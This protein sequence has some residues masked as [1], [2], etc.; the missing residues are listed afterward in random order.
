[1]FS[2]QHPSLHLHIY[3]TKALCPRWSHCHLP[4]HGERH[5]LAPR[6]PS[7]PLLLPPVVSLLPSSATHGAAPTP[8]PPHPL[9]RPT[10]SQICGRRR[11]I[12]LAC[13]VKEKDNADMWAHI[14]PHQ[15]KHEK[16]GPI[17]LRDIYI[18]IYV[19]FFARCVIVDG[20]DFRYCGLGTSNS[21]T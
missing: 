1:M 18:Y 13:M 12:D 20:R 7:P 14:M 17:L 16:I 3:F 19:F 4:C 6:R 8:A 11:V 21:S 2:R 9:H 10:P 15:L 5:G